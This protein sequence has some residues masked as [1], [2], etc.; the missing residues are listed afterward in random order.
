MDHSEH[1][2]ADDGDVPNSRLPL[3]VYAGIIDPKAGDPAQTF[4]ALFASNGW[5][6]M[7]RN[8]IFP[9]HHYHSTAHEALGIARGSAEVR[10]GGERRDTGGDRRGLADVHEPRTG[11]R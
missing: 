8:G 1:V 11:V 2:F 9:F 4:E 7:W 5:G 10:F 6:G 3:I